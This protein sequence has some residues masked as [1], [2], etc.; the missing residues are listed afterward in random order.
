MKGAAVIAFTGA[1]LRCRLHITHIGC[2]GE[3][4][5]TTELFGQLHCV[6]IGNILPA[7]AVQN[8]YFW[9]NHSLM[10]LQVVTAVRKVETLVVNWEVGDTLA[11]N[12]N[13]K[14]QPVVKAWILNLVG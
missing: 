2:G 11:T 4:G 7:V 10:F 6:Q 12:G 9:S 13:G 1:E 8:F 3:L 14:S 5:T